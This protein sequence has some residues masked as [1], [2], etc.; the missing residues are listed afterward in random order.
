MFSQIY[1]FFNVNLPCEC[2]VDVFSK[3]L[4]PFVTVVVACPR[5]DMI[6]IWPLPVVDPWFEDWWE[7]P[8]EMMLNG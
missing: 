3:A 5:R 6:R 1:G 8:G 2:E 4:Q 7:G